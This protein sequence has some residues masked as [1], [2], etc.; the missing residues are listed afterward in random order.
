MFKKTAIVLLC[1]FLYCCDN[2]YSPEYPTLEKLLSF[3]EQ[4]LINAR[5]YTLETYL[6][7][8]FMPSCPPDGRPLIAL[9]RV[10]A[11]DQLPFSSTLDADRL[12]IISGQEVWETEFSD[13]EIPP[14]PNRE[15]QLEK[16][17]RDGPKWGP[18]IY[19]DVV[20]RITDYKFKTYYLRASDQYIGATY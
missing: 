16:I 1:L 17:A 4:I 11:V 10:S 3:P 2:P 12:W 13:E 19:V 14:D 20:V 18:D 9:I 8:D 7:R 15:H 5:L 6:W